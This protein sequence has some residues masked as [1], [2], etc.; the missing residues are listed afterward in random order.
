MVIVI[1][2]ILKKHSS[3]RSVRHLDLLSLYQAVQIGLS[4]LR[5]PCKG[6]S[7]YG[8]SRLLGSIDEVPDSSEVHRAVCPHYGSLLHGI[9]GHYLIKVGRNYLILR[10]TADEALGIDC[11]AQLEIRRNG[12]VNITFQDVICIQVVVRKS[13]T[14]LRIR[15]FVRT[16]AVAGI[17]SR[18][19]T[20][21]VFRIGNRLLDISTCIIIVRKTSC[22]QEDCQSSCPQCQEK[23]IHGHSSVILSMII[24][25]PPKDQKPIMYRC[26]GL[27]VLPFLSFISCRSTTIFLEFPKS[28]IAGSLQ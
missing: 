16:G 24:G 27:M 2:V 13:F 26:E 1:E 22:G 12:T 9:A 7:V 11:C 4:L 23:S 25:L 3:P 8:H 14:R 6:M 5:V 20:V 18:I 28:Y 15:P 19:S 21:A 10:R 17:S